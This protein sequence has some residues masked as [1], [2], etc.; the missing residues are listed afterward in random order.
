MAPPPDQYRHR[1]VADLAWAVYSPPLLLRR[2]SAC[3]WFE[4]EWYLDQYRQIE[5]L[6]QQLDH[7]P[8][9]L[10]SLLAAQK[11]QRLGNYF[12]TLWAFALDLHPRYRLVERNLQI[13]DGPN[14]LGEMD[15]IVFDEQSG[16]YAH[17]ELAVK[18]YLGVGDTL[19]Y[20]AW[21]GPGKQDRLD[22]KVDHLLSRQIALSNHPVARAMLRERGIEIEDS[23]IILKGRL[24]YPL[25]RQDDDSA[26]VFSNPG[27]LKGVWLTRSELFS[28]YDRAA[29]FMP[30]NRFGWMADYPVAVE[31]VGHRIEDLLQQVDRGEY[32]LP[33][34]LVRQEN[35]IAR[36][37]LF[38]VGDDWPGG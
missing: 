4:G 21:Q 26:P 24:F 13:V 15:F 17:W 11:D 10:E 23:G 30:L 37:R 22:I 2:D 25:Q 1:C 14:T 29:R 9:R 34:H 38:I 27:H 7:N 6:L 12:E 3:T 16:R 32:R 8:A 18:F 35:G 19:K 5:A 20:A 36:E 31:A 33:L 28:R